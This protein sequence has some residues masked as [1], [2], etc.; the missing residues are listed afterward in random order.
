MHVSHWSGNRARQ[1]EHATTCITAGMNKLDLWYPWYK[2]NVPA[3]SWLGSPC[4]HAFKSW[5]NAEL[6][7]TTVLTPYTCIINPLVIPHTSANY[8]KVSVRS[9]F[10][11]CSHAWYMYSCSCDR[12]GREDSD[13]LSARKRCLGKKRK[14][15]ASNKDKETEVEFRQREGGELGVPFAT[16]GGTIQPWYY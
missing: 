4:T 10:H 14:K 3:S 16:K 13:K 9:L 11:S 8:T 15:V 12:E 6:E 2:I 1:K 5:L 7:H